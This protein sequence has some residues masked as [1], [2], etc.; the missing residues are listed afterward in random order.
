MSVGNGTADYGIVD[1]RGPCA[2]V[3]VKVAVRKRPNAGWAESPDF[4]QTRRY[5]DALQCPSVLVDSHFVYLIAPFGDA[6]YRIIERRT[7]TPTDLEALRN[8]LCRSG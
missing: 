2:I 4:Q 5:A 6:P 8:H 1:S 3:E 7:A